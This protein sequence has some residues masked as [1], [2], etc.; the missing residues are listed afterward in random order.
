MSVTTKQHTCKNPQDPAHAEKTHVFDPTLVVVVVVR[1]VCNVRISVYAHA[2]CICLKRTSAGA[3]VPS[4]GLTSRKP[5]MPVGSESRFQASPV[6]EVLAQE[7][8]DGGAV[9]AVAASQRRH[10]QEKSPGS[11]V[12]DRGCRYLRPESP[13]TEA[14]AVSPEVESCGAVARCTSRAPPPPGPWLSPWCGVVRGS[15]HDHGDGHPL[16]AMPLTEPSL[17]PPRPLQFRHAPAR[18]QLPG[19]KNQQKSIYASTCLS[20]EGGVCGV[21][22]V[23]C[24][25]VWCGVVWCGVVWCG[26]VWCGVVWCGVV[27]CGV[28]WCG[29]SD[30]TYDVRVYPCM[31]TRV[32]LIKM[33]WCH[34]PEP[35]ACS[36]QRQV[37]G[38]RSAKPHHPQGEEKD[39]EARPPHPPLL[40]RKGSAIFSISSA[41]DALDLDQHMKVHLDVSS[42]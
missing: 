38:V 4:A 30:M 17:S 36:L 14:W 32:H 3:L 10:H 8:A 2:Q 23:W 41:L 29:G 15:S 31:S 6:Q 40:R 19:T 25:V 37:P 13:Q 5:P 21:V 42:W 27:W 35:L 11:H 20:L 33:G 7:E 9:N 34:R 18:R 22:C 12:T 39:C 24:G 28:V 16:V 26:V 1:T